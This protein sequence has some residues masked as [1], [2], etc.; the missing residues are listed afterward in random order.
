MKMKNK[1]RQ[2]NRGARENDTGEKGLAGGRAAVA[3]RQDVEF[4][5]KAMFSQT[6]AVAT[7]EGKKP[8]FT[9]GDDV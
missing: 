5:T 8:S 6:A 7:R 4:S 3:E 9:K 1:K 2:H